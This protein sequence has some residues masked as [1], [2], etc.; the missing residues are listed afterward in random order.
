MKVI[1]VLANNSDTMEGNNMNYRV[2]F[3]HL[4]WHIKIVA[5][6]CV[7]LQEFFYSTIIFLK[8]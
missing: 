8:M 4:L 5:T 6:I 3:S 7:S 1:R 2:S